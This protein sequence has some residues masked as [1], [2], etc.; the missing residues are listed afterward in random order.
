LVSKNEKIGAD[1]FEYIWYVVI[2]YINFYMGDFKWL[3]R[4]GIYLVLFVCSLVLIF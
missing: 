3:K 2:E 4:I 1:N